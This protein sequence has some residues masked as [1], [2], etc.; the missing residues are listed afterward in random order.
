MGDDWFIMIWKIFGRIG[1]CPNQLPHQNLTGGTEGNQRNL[2]Q[3][4]RRSG[5]LNTNLQIYRYTNM[6]RYNENNNNYY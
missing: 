6:F 3:H 1:S 5:H 4:R 2:S